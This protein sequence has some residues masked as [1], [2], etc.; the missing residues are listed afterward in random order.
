VLGNRPLLLFGL[1]AV[2][3]QASHATFYGF[4]S[5]HWRAQGVDDAVIGLL[6]A[7][8][9]LAETV[10]FAVS[11]R[12]VDRLGIVAL[13]RLAALAGLLRWTGFALE[14]GLLPAFALMALHAGTFGATHLATMHF[15]TRLAPADSAAT[16]Q[17]LF[18]AASGLAM[19]LAASASGFLYE[20]IGATAYLAMAA[21]ALAAGTLTWR[22]REPMIER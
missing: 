18:S 2:L 19:G 20:E 16:A 22:L 1:T 15:I 6:W 17:A 21:L 4:A 8:G 10:L 9:V 7:A 14:P 13:L 3:L 11:G 12:A 5:L